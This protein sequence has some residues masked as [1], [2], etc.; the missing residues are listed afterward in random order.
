MKIELH[1]I[2]IKDVFEGYKDSAENGVVGYNGLLNVRP[3]FQ[4]EFVYKDKQ[5]DEVIKTISTWKNKREKKKKLLKKMKNKQAAVGAS[6]FDL[7]CIADPA[8]AALIGNLIKIFIKYYQR[9]KIKAENKKRFGLGV[10]HTTAKIFFV[11]SESH[12][13]SP[14]FCKTE[15]KNYQKNL[16]PNGAQINAPKSSGLFVMPSYI[17]ILMLFE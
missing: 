5:R 7:G 2:P 4:R 3:A 8:P 11:I 10:N 14:L 13:I 6:G 12:N 17:N 1:E 9:E 15:N 16:L